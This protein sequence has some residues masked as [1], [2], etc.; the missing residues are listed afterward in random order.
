MQTVLT[1]HAL[2]DDVL[3]DFGDGLGRDAVRYRNHVYR[4]LN[5]QRMLLGLDT[6]PDDIAL[7][8]ALHDIGIWITGWD[9]IPPSLQ[10]IDELA[11]RFGI[12][13]VDRVRRMVALHHKV[14]P[15]QDKWVETFRLA[16]RIDVTKGLLRK[17]LTRSQMADVVQAFPY[18]GF[19]A[20]L[21]RTAARWAATHP[22]RPLPMLRW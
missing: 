21:V 10:Q 17:D 14:R 3:G 22:L 2:V 9:Y 5:Y 20:L 15:S 18:D 11:P 19:H 4:G 6:I 12:D 1:N 8:W 7:A 13:D 16:D